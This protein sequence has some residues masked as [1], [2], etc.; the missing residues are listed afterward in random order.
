MKSSHSDQSEE[1]APFLRHCADDWPTGR[2]RVSCAGA[3]S[4]FKSLTKF[5][6]S[7]NETQVAK[8]IRPNLSDEICSTNAGER[9]LAEDKE[10][11]ANLGYTTDQFG[12]SVQPISAEF[13]RLADRTEPKTWTLRASAGL[14]KGIEWPAMENPD[15]RV[16]FS[17]E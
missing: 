14:D 7:A 9:I 6:S 4:N 12:R 1:P 11:S 3:L 15:S 8:F 5:A 13:F 2:R 17:L 16:M 10:G